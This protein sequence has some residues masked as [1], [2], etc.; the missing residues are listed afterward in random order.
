MN[1]KAHHLH[2]YSNLKPFGEDLLG[3]E[4]ELRRLHHNFSGPPRFLFTIAEETRE[5]MESEDD[6]S[7][8]KLSDLVETPFLTP[9]ANSPP[10]FTPPLTPTHNEKQGFNPFCELASDAA[11]NCCL[12]SSPPPKFKFLKDAEDKL[13][14]RQLIMNDDQSVQFEVPSTSMFIKDEENGSFITLIVAQNKQEEETNRV[15]YSSN[16][17][18]VFSLPSSSLNFKLPSDKRPMH[19]KLNHNI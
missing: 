13:Q 19:Q 16:T 9:L 10:Y 3:V 1:H 5:E 8:K 11:F 14:R 15:N 4:A 17:S 12:R 18:Q 2:V 6:T 7:R